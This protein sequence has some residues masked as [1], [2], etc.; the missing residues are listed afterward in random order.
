VAVHA[1]PYTDPA[2]PSSWAREPAMWALRGKFGD[3]VG[4]TYVTSGLAREV[5]VVEGWSPRGPMS[6]DASGMPDV[7]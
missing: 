4:I 2:C 3:G 1:Y 7:R 6:A 5:G